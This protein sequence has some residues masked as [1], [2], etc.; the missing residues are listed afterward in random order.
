[1]TAEYQSSALAIILSAIGAIQMSEID[2]VVVCYK[3]M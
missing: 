3:I 2:K 1:M